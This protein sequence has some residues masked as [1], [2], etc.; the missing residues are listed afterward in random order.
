MKETRGALVP[1]LPGLAGLAVGWWIAQTFT[2]SP[3]SATLHSW[4]LGDGPRH[5][6][7]S[8]TLH[9]MNFWLPLVAAALASYA[10][11]RLAAL[12]RSRYSPPPDAVVPGEQLR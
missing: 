11:S 7:R 10:G 1:R 9:A 4:G 12:I 8:D 5:A 2:D 6:V 3:L